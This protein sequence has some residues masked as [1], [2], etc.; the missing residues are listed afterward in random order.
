MSGLFVCC[1][2]CGHADLDPRRILVGTNQE[3]IDDIHYE[4]IITLKCQG[5]GWLGEQS[6]NAEVP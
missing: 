5:C 6:A 1:P 3:R 2:D 4:E